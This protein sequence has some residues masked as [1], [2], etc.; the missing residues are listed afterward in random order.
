LLAGNV[1]TVCGA[2]T[3]FS[4]WALG[5]VLLSHL[6]GNMACNMILISHKAQFK[7]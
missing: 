6:A 5:G 2:D 3:L 7:K 4:I 1:K